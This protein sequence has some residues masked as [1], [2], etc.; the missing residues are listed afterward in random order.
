MKSCAICGAANDDSAMMCAYCGSELPVTAPAAGK[1]K[2]K[3]LF[4][5]KKNQSSAASA[6]RVCPTCGTM[7]GASDLYCAACF[8]ELGDGYGQSTGDGVPNYC[9]SCGT[10]NAPGEMCCSVCGT[11]LGTPKKKEKK[12]NLGKIAWIGAGVAAIAAVAVGVSMIAGSLFANPAVK[13]VNSMADA[14]SGQIHKMAKL[15]EFADNFAALNESGEFAVILDVELPQDELMGTVYYDR[16]AKL[17]SG[18]LELDSGSL[19]M[20]GGVDFSLSNKEIMLRRQGSQEIFGCNMNGLANTLVVQMINNNQALAKM[21]VHLDP[22]LLNN[23][24]KKM[25]NPED[26]EK[27]LGKAWKKL[28]NSL[29]VDE[30]AEQDGYRV[31]AVSIEEDAIEEFLDAILGEGEF[32][33]QIANFL[34]GM[35]PDIHLYIDSDGNLAKA[36]MIFSGEKCYL[37]FD[38]SA[39]PLA[40][41][42]ITSE[43][44]NIRGELTSD[45]SGLNMVFVCPMGQTYLALNISYDDASGDFHMDVDFSNGYHWELDGKLTSRNGQA[46]VELN[47]Y[48]PNVGD[49]QVRIGLDKLAVQPEKLSSNGK[50]LDMLDFDNINRLIQEFSR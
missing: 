42:T 31:Y 43:S 17:M 18:S 48:V 13:A 22:N 26:L 44:G 46:M 14:A 41:C 36:D 29:E 45:S 15:G 19:S 23:L 35:G 6:G 11:A 21:G 32:R 49:V 40:H 7:N 3:S 25:E 50:Y 16:Q 20:V 1:K 9:P 28:C 27:E 39:D 34:T 33:K 5:K 24:F 12:S 2:K 8:T 38:D 30:T 4:G 10:E 37:E 47:G